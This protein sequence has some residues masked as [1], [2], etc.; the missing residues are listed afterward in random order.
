M[1]IL[2]GT[3]RK[4]EYLG[5]P[6]M[7]QHSF[8]FDKQANDCA[9]Q[10]NSPLMRASQGVRIVFDERNAVNGCCEGSVPDIQYMSC[11]YTDLVS[12]SL[13]IC[14][15]VSIIQVQQGK[16]IKMLCTR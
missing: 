9:G 3:F 4:R 7:P 2:A 16:P 15:F 12:A 14:S 1:Y 10:L 13:S 11:S 6:E 8:S 5:H